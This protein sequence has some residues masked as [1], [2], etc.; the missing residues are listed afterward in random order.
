MGGCSEN[1][2]WFHDFS[3]EI[4][5]VLKNFRHVGKKM[6][7]KIAPLIPYK[8]LQQGAPKETSTSSTRWAPTS[9]K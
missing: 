1:D 3:P 5:F 4:F 9:Y 2:G 8:K 6:E 7:E